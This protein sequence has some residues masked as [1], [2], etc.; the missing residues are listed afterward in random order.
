MSGEQAAQV[1]S[2]IKREPGK[3]EPDQEERARADEIRKTYA[4]QGHPYYASA[5]LWNDGIIAPTATRDILGRCLGIVANAPTPP[6]RF[7]VFRM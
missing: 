5:R 4:T 7:G 2:R 3:T 6:T 1:L